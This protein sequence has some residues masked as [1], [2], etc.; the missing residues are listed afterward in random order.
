M[1]LLQ[2][3][4]RVTWVQEYLLF[5]TTFVFGGAQIN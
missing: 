2:K 4:E 1:T 3:H 5:F